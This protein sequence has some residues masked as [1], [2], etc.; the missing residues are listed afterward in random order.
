M[1]RV[2]TL[3]LIVVAM[4]LTADGRVSL[5]QQSTY[6]PPSASASSTA[7]RPRLTW[8]AVLAKL[9]EKCTPPDTGGT[10]TAIQAA[11][12]GERRCLE[13]TLAA[14]VARARSVVPIDGR[15][16]SALEH[17]QAAWKELMEAICH[18]REELYWVRFSELVH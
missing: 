6:S 5:A 17:Q 3:S 13:N 14:Q 18:L 16:L 11:L 15:Q 1:D 9:R 7:T 12:M 10:T 4:G 8:D 2:A